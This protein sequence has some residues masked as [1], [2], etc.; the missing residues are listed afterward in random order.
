MLTVSQFIELLRNAP[1]DALMMGEFEGSIYPL[2]ADDVRIGVAHEALLLPAGYNGRENDYTSWCSGDGSNRNDSP[3]IRVNT[4]ILPSVGQS[5][6][7]FPKRLDN[8]DTEKDPD[9]D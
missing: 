8:K 9:C 5:N 1:G 2:D 4:V 7:D 3:I 6:L